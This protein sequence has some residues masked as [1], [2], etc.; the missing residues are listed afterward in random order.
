MRILA[1]VSVK[2]QNISDLFSVNSAAVLFVLIEFVFSDASDLVTLVF[3][4]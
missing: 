4:A 1:A 3:L 2:Q